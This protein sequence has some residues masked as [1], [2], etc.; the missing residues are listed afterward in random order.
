MAS[1]AISSNSNK[2]KWAITILIPVIIFL[3]P[4]TEVYTMTMKKFFIITVFSLLCAAFEFFPNLVIGLMIPIGYV[5]FGVAPLATVTSP[6]NQPL[7]FQG[8]GAFILAGVMQVSG[9]SRRLSFWLMSKTGGNYTMTLIAFFLTSV[10]LSAVTFG[11]TAALMAALCLGLCYSLDIVGTKMAAGIGMAVLMGCCTSIGFTYVISTMAMLNSCAQTVVPGFAVSFTDM[12]LHNWPMFFVAL[13]IVLIVAKWYKADKTISSKEYFEGQLH[14]LGAMSYQEKCAVTLL[15][16]LILALVT[17][18]WH[19]IDGSIF[20]MSMPLLAFLPIF[21]MDAKQIIG[22]VPIDLMFF[23]AACMSIGTVATTLGFG[24]IFAD[25]ILPIIS[26][27]TGLILL[28]A[29]LMVVVFL[30]NF[31]MTPFAIWGIVTAP[32]VAAVVSAGYEPSAFIYGLVHFSDLILLPYE[33]VPYLTVY[34]L[35]LMS[36]KDFVKFSILK[37]VVYGLGFFVIL[38]PY[39]HL[40]GIL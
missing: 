12:Y 11:G 36:M 16:V 15:A 30:A 26:S 4:C 20:F 38:M 23:M 32:L 34:A 40:I 28:F 18:K 31:V 29:I 2:I 17:N 1:Q 27:G 35:G 9:L 3:I 25:L 21:K 19:G 6:W 14:E 13:L 33:Y 8:L 39:W 37:C 10:V 7:V 24:Q 22:C 5:V